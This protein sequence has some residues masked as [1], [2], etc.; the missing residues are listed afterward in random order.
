MTRF[1]L[2]ALLGLV[3]FLAGCYLTF[4]VGPAL[5]A[6]GTVGLAISLLVDVDG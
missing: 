3:V 5:M 1:A 4:G 2:M 6:A